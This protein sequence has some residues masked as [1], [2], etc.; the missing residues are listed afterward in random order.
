MGEFAS[1]GLAL[2]VGVPALALAGLN[3]LNNG[4][5]GGILG[6][7]NQTALQAENAQLKAEKYTDHAV[8]DLYKANQAELEKRDT[9]I[10]AALI[11]EGKQQERINCLVKDVTRLQDVT[12]VQNVELA[13]I[14]V[15]EAETNGRINMVAQV[16]K[17]RNEATRIEFM[18]ALGC[19]T[20][21][22]K[23]ADQRIYDWA[24]CTFVEG[25]KVIPAE[26]ICPS[27]VTSRDVVNYYQAGNTAQTPS[28]TGGTCCVSNA[29]SG[30]SLNK[31]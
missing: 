14:R 29:I 11:E 24:S 22:R 19:E 21:A 26:D 9:V 2:G 20:E 31:K 16:S 7:G 25:K 8:L 4:S 18:N 17:E 5:L 13:D 30:S 6:G 28:A 1:K 10:T 12:A 15:R 27:V 23:V 3:T